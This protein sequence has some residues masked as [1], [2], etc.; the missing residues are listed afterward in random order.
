MGIISWIVFGFIIGLLARAL[1]PGRQSM[2]FIMTTLLGVAGSL[3]GGLIATALS[4]GSMQEMHGAGFLGS[5]IGAIV[6]LL[7][8]G[9]AMGSRR[10]AAV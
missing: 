3:I 2:G 10:R 8:A 9:V 1:V 4:G 6:L 7:V 5:L